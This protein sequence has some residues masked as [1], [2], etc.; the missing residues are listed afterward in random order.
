MAHRPRGRIGGAGRGSGD[1]GVEYRQEGGCPA[2]NDGSLGTTRPWGLG[3][4]FARAG[5]VFCHDPARGR[6]QPA[7]LRTEV[8]ALMPELPHL[9]APSSR[10]LGRRG[11]PERRS[12]VERSIHPQREK[13]RLR[14]II[15]TAGLE[16]GAPRGTAI[17]PLPAATAPV[18]SVPWRHSGPQWPQRSA[19][20]PRHGGSPRRG[21][22]LH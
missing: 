15:E 21:S 6:I 11:G 2:C 12:V 5:W 13:C 22:S 18:R 3:T 16:T 4:E 8:R 14:R 9:G 7:L 20:R 19:G 10:R 17:T 1:G